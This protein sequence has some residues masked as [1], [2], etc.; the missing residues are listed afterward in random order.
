MKLLLIFGPNL[1]LLGVR[2]PEIYGTQTLPELFGEIEKYANDKGVYVDYIQTNHEG[3]II[4]AIHD[5][6]GV[7]DGII[8]NAGAY[9]HYSYAI[10]DAIEA[11]LPLPCYD[12]HLSDINNREDF[13]KVS[14]IKDV[15]K[16]QF[17]GKGIN[18]YFEA[19]DKFVE[20][21]NE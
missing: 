18:S 21:F 14:V 13:R 17:M 11:I 4:D 20:D 1:N 10:R 3:D 15:C 6:L 7:V 5:S 2:K 12:V 8:I 9:T 19:I 16:A